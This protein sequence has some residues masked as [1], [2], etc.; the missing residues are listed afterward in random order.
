V[1]AIAITYFVLATAVAVATAAMSSALAPVP[2][3]VSDSV[4]PKAEPF[5]LQSVRL[6]D[7]PFKQAMQLDQEYLL[8]L[9][10]DRLL[11]NFRVNAGLSS[12]AKPLGGWEAPDV[13][14]RGHTVGHYL[15]A[16]ALMYAATGDARFKDRAD[17]MVRELARIQEA[18]AKR[19][20]PGYLSAFPEEFF[21]RV[22]AREKV[23]APYYT[24]HKIMAGLLD[25]SE[26]C[27]NPQALEVVTRMA[28]WVAFRVDRIS[29]AQ[30]QRAL[31][32]E[33]GGMNE[34]LAN[35]YAAT[36]NA[37]YLR[38][39]HAFDHEA[40]FDPL[41]RRED[42]LNGLHANTQFPKIIGAAREYE[43]TGD[44]RYQRIATFFWDRVVHHRSYVTGGNSDGEAFFPEEEFSKHLGASGPETCNTYNMLK[45][46]RH[47]FEWSADA[48]AMDFYE[49]GLFNHILPS[50][51]PET[52]M[53]IYYCPLRPGAWKSYSTPDDSFWCCVGTGMENHTKYGDTIYFHDDRSL[54][55]NL[56]I[57]SDLTWSAKGIS[58]R[59]QTRFPEE[60]AT[61]L[62]LTATTPTRLALKVRY[63]SWARSGMAISVNGRPEPQEP[64]E[65]QE[66]REPREPREQTTPSTASP[67]SYITIDREWRTGDRVDVRLPM[68]L[69][70]EAMPDNPHMV[71]VM[72]GPIVLAGDLGQDGLEGVKRYGPSAPAVG[73]VATPVIPSFVGDA[74]SLTSKIVPD[75]AGPLQF[76]TS[77]LAR[78][79]EVTL[80]PF[81]RIVN[82]RY[83]V[84]WN[85]YSADE[86]NAR[87]S[88]VAASAARRRDNQRGTL[89][90]V[91]V[92][93]AESERSHALKS[94]NATDSYF[95]GRRTRE[96]RNGW[97][98]YDVAV[99]PDRP[100]TIVCAY[101][102]S[103]GRRRV[104]DVLVDG[105]RIATETLE[106]HPTEQLDKEYAI[107][108]ALTRGRQRVT[109]TFQA[110][111]DATAGALIE[112]R[113]V[114]VQP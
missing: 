13:E 11:H 50:Q 72:Y 25:V 23:W 110:L 61:H 82:Q 80:L 28:D 32:T 83:T 88:A 91:A 93:D 18:Q 98:S 92:Y 55:V 94:E 97:F 38:V 81:Y 15:S 4:T 95:E 34:V 36:G 100:M 47:I 6:L 112:V 45:L 27:G 78:P 85:M 79:H 73:R 17:A 108:D 109:V 71:A 29:Q 75:R 7:G 63:P 70:T 51:D 67:G 3:R 12:S 31:G 107:P 44:A 49:R 1:R 42:P 52:G 101:R 106:Y 68:T 113:T 99:A 35:I 26:L 48:G 30:Q 46:T 84:Y 5:P 114:T 64:Q 16:L 69:H 9:E 10:P 86:W 59:Q 89:D 33:F 74:K 41:A 19:F 65:P 22:E 66:P 20:H 77:G 87:E 102:G 105:Q 90:L 62:T 57:P 111:A 60:E 58:V 39:A 76:K 56:F 21:D 54:Y 37:A 24:I 43:L 40:I 8:A 104:F 103:E 53:V 14:L 96:A 2:A